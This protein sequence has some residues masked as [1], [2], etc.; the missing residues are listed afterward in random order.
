MYTVEQ[1]LD[2]LADVVTG[3][4]A[5]TESVGLVHALGRTL[6]QPVRMDTDIPPFRRATMDGFAVLTRDLE[7]G[8]DL[9]IVGAV[10]AGESF[11]RALRPG[12]A[13]HVMTGAPVPGGS[14]AVVPVE[15][16]E[17]TDTVV[18]FS[19]VPVP[20]TTYISEP[21][22]HVAAGSLVAT[23]HQRIDPGTLA[24]LATAGCASVPVYAPP[25][26][27]ILGTGDELVPPQETPGPGRI[28]NSNTYLLHGLAQRAGATPIDRG[29]APDD[30]A[31]LG[32][33][34]A[35]ALPKVNVLLLTGGVSMGTKDWVPQVLADQGVR[36]LFHRWSV[37]PGGPLWCGHRDRQI[38]I[39]LPGNP[40][41][42]YVGFEVL[43]VPVLRALLGAP[44]APRPVVAATLN[45]DWGR[46]GPRRRF[47]PVDLSVDDEGRM[48]ATPR[49]WKGSGD[50]FSWGDIDAL[51][52][53]PEGLDR[54]PSSGRV[55]VLPL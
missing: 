4:A 31:L 26:V 3:Q 30:P 9:R 21:G 50:P 35:A 43:V 14:G 1:A 39:G 41:A 20:G 27:G 15:W 11:S 25:R 7:V 23:A 52:I 46:A 28:R 22:S 8:R 5:P 44:L 48:V 17:H 49:S 51:A 37:Q 42:V 32:E 2:A 54:P 36:C 6:A 12:E 10:H 16:C 53:L 55:D 34:V 47:R 29:V 45:G 19:R 33:A 18:S 38:V 13:V 40:A 24:I